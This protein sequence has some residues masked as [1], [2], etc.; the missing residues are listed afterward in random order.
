[1]HVIDL[2]ANVVVKVM[3]VCY[4]SVL[5]VIKQHD[6]NNSRLNDMIFL[7]IKIRWVGS[8]LLTL[9]FLQEFV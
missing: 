1:M 7:E 5:F 6:M 3:S 4:F 8:M 9:E 2:Q